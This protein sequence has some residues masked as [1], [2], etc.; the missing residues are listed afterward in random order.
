MRKWIFLSLVV[1]LLGSCTPSPI[2]YDENQNALLMFARLKAQGG[3]PMEGSL[4]NSVPD[5]RIWGDGRVVTGA[6]TDKGRQISLGHLEKAQIEDMLGMLRNAGF[7]S[8]WTPDIGALNP[9]GMGFDLV[10]NL[11]SGAYSY[12]WG[13]MGPVYPEIYQEMLSK[14]SPTELNP[15]TPE[16]ATLM[17]V[18]FTYGGSENIVQWPAQ[19]SFS[20]KDVTSSGRIIEGE[21]LAFIWQDVNQ[22][23]V[24]VVM[25]DNTGYLV[26]LVM[27]EISMPYSGYGCP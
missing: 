21:P 24:P 9:G 10:V 12:S 3:A 25:D 17:A 7:F 4:C 11:P 13:W 27:P 18:P 14:I 22:N 15:F 6:Y 23:Y 2:P 5:L 26:W 20:L 19:F 8:N 16:R 1:L